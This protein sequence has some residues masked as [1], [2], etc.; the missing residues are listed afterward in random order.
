MSKSG[1]GEQVSAQNDASAPLLTKKPDKALYIPPARRST[2][3]VSVNSGIQVHDTSETRNSANSSPVC[4]RSDVKQ[5]LENV[6]SALRIS[7]GTGAPA[8]KRLS[9]KSSVPRNG[10]H[11][12]P[13]ATIDYSKFLHVI[14]LYDFPKEI[15]TADLQAEL[16]GFE[17][18]GFYLKW[19]DDT[20]CLAVFSS[21]TEAE[22]ALKQI[23]GIM[24]KVC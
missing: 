12:S 15:E 5:S 6:L 20:H 14:E 8:I 23:S 21:P 19:V 7:D 17:D 4:Q 16:V 3:G 1:S 22:R 13:E 2:G 18:S 9:S 10:N 11:S 24:F